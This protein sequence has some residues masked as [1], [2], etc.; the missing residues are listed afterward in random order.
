V[1]NVD[2]LRETCL[3][4]RRRLE[5]QPHWPELRA[6]YLELAP[7]AGQLQGAVRERIRAEGGTEESR[8]AEASLSRLQ[9]GMRQVGLD[10]RLASEPALLLGL[11]TCLESA[12]ETVD[13]LQRMNGP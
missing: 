2:E 1:E 13:Y 6:V 8:Q 10:I 4:L 3:A 7:L 11:Q 9:A 5:G 12:L